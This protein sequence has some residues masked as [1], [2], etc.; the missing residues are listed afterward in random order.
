MSTQTINPDP[1]V[2]NCPTDAEFT[3][4]GGT[5]LVKPLHELLNRQ[6]YHLSRLPGYFHSTHG[7][8]V[9]VFMSQLIYF[10]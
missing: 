2:W 1:I 8:T 10:I 3:W 9:I 5:E 7:L 4:I 6:L